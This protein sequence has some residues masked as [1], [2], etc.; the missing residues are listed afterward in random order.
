MEALREFHACDGV[1]LPFGA[2]CTAL[3]QHGQDIIAQAA[4][5]AAARSGS[6]AA[7]GWLGAR[8]PVVTAPLERDGE[9]SATMAMR[10]IPAGTAAA[11]GGDP[12]GWLHAQLRLLPRQTGDEAITELLLTVRCEVSP[13]ALG[14]FD[15]DHCA[16][17]LRHA[18]AELERR[19][20]ARPV[21]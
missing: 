9:R 12:A 15:P 16:G 6:A 11:A 19:A 5:L 13:A 10:W 17:F 4:L 1:R 20:A 21:R 18:A 7:A 2:A 8:S 3:E 14:A